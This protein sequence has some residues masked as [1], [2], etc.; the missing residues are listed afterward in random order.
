MHDIRVGR[1]FLEENA[2]NASKLLACFQ[3]KSLEAGQEALKT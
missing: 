3:T 2:V 1:R